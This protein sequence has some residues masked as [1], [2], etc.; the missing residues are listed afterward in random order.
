MTKPGGSAAVYLI[1]AALVGAFL[2]GGV[3]LM[4]LCV[5]TFIQPAEVI[6]RQVG[7]V[8]GVVG[9][10]A[11]VP[12]AIWALAFLP[13]MRARIAEGRRAVVVRGWAIIATWAVLGVILLIVIEMLD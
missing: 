2:G 10:I 12:A 6:A 7:T 3:A 4:A 11:A 9:A 1:T 5:W 13:W 8:A